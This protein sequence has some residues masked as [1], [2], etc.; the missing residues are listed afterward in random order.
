MNK[1]DEEQ[2]VSTAGLA[3]LH[4]LL[5]KLPPSDRLAGRRQLLVAFQHKGLWVVRVYK[6][7]KTPKEVVDL[8]LTVGIWK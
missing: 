1:W 5:R 2:P 8:A 7:E 4:T 6:R 3:K